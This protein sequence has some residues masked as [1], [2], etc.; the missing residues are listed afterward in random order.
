MITKKHRPRLVPAV[1]VRL[2]QVSAP[3]NQPLGSA[4]IL[5]WLATR[6]LLSRH[7][8]RTIHWLSGASAEQRRLHCGCFGWSRSS[9][10][11]SSVATCSPPSV[12]DCASR[13]VGRLV[14]PEQCGSCHSCS[15]WSA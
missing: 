6:A 12:E 4:F 8:G 13:V 9:C 2:P 3:A 14:A 5:A 15:A 11:G 1:S 10:L 7:W